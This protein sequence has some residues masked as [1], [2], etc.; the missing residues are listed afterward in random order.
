MLVIISGQKH[1]QRCSHKLLK[2]ST[3]WV[4]VTKESPFQSRHLTILADIFQYFNVVFKMLL[5]DIY[6][7][8]L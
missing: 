7:F 5:V 4:P 8:A 1:L 2:R 6:F 3:Q